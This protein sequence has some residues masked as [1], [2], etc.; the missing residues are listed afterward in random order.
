MNPMLLRLLMA[1][2]DDEP[3]LPHYPGGD[4]PRRLGVPHFPGGPLMGE[5]PL[6]PEEGAPDYIV[7]QGGPPND[8]NMGG[9]PGGG[10]LQALLAGGQDMRRRQGG[11][12]MPHGPF[13]PGGMVR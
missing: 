10:I 8:P 3:M 4:L 12:R 1:Q 6:M 5:E 2:Q 13:P 7:G 11:L 9:G